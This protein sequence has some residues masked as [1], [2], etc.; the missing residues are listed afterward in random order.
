[1]THPLALRRENRLP[2]HNSSVDVKR[3]KVSSFNN[4][5]NRVL[6]DCS[7]LEVFWKFPVLW[8]KHYFG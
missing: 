7:L 4:M 3:I 5:Y 6:K 1:M 8:L 2:E